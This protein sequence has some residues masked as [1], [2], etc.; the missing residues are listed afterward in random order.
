[1]KNSMR[2]LGLIAVLSLTLACASTSA[3]T[4]SLRGVAVNM[5]GNPLP[6]TGTGQDRR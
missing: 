1:M 4:G 3:P 6:S 2:R 5:N